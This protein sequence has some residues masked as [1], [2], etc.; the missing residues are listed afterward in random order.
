LLPAD[1]HAP[2]APAPLVEVKAL[3]KRY[4][5]N[6]GFIRR[7]RGRPPELL[8]ALDNVDLTIY[9]GEIVGLV[10]ESGSGKT[11]LG[12][13]MLR[14]IEPSGGQVL[15]RGADILRLPRRDLLAIRRKAQMVFQDPYSSLNPRLTVR[16][17][18]GEALTFHQICTRSEVEGRILALLRQVGLP[19]DAIDR[20]PRHF[21]GGQ[22]QRIGI[23]RA[24]AVNPEFIVADEPVSAVDVSIQAQVLNLLVELKEQLGLT[25]L[26]IAH[27][28]GV[29]K[30]ISTRVGVMYL[31]RIV[32]IAPKQALF[33][34]PRHPY[35]QGLLLASPEPDPLL[36]TANVA[37]EG[38]PPSPLHLPSGCRFRTRCPLASTRCHHEEPALQHL[39]GGHWVA[40]HNHEQAVWPPAAHS[41]S[42]PAPLH[43]ERGA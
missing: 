16:Q 14:L 30:Y 12:R 43:L 31:G 20:A 7:L 27:N 32:E 38:E 5:I 28:L 33:R 41:T 4:P 42:P 39:G 37:L 17:A 26:F 36:K 3:A 9:P 13:C 23:A 40:C 10:G 18:I 21:S 19:D 6:D 15:Y 35:T 8:H 11:T 22:R 2:G 34:R 24:L 1:P 29:V 25:M